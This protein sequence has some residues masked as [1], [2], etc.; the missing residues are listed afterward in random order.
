MSKPDPSRVVEAARDF[1]VKFRGAA[2]RANVPGYD[3]F[4]L[5][6]LVIDAAR[7]LNLALEGRAMFDPPRDV[8]EPIAEAFES[9]IEYE[10][11]IP[12]EA[13]RHNLSRLLRWIGYVDID[14]G[15][16]SGLPSI[17]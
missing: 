10:A 1:I 3:Q 2:E 6:G 11:S 12:I 8:S 5:Q 13:M 15:P 4:R 14:V 16:K 9:L 7:D 17:T